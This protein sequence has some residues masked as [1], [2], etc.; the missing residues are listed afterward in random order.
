MKKTSCLL[1]VVVIACCAT[2]RAQVETK[3]LASAQAPIQATASAPAQTQPGHRSH[4][5]PPQHRWSFNALGGSAFPIGSFAH[6]D[7]GNPESGSV[8]TGSLFE[9]SATYQLSHTWGITLLGNHQHHN[10]EVDETILPYMLPDVIGPGPL[11]SQRDYAAPPPQHWSMTRLLAGGVYTLPLN[12]KKSL[13]LLFRALAGIQQTHVSQYEYSV[14]YQNATAFAS[15]P[16]RNLAWALSYQAD[17]GL[18]WKLY[19]R[20]SL[21]AF[22]G[23]NGSRPSYNQDITTLLQAFNGMVPGPGIGPA[24]KKIDFPT[25][26]ILV[27]TG[28]GFD[29]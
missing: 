29:L 23:Y 17:A 2:A 20:W 26:S 12:K 28:V 1:L 6:T 13:A 27:R 15:F 3:P 7:D 25:G 9:G 5:A 8:H 16:A 21:L 4:P 24:F 10:S 19:R 22:A 11:T 18:Q 14:K